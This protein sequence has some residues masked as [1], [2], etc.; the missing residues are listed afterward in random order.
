MRRELDDERKFSV[1]AAYDD[2]QLVLRYDVRQ[3]PKGLL[4]DLQKLLKLSHIG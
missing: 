2:E 3:S 4:S 1:S